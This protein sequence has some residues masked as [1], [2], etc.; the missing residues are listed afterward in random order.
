MDLIYLIAAVV[1]LI[2]VIVLLLKVAKKLVKFG[3]FLLLVCA[4]VFIVSKFLNLI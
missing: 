3:L 1:V 4:A 2:V